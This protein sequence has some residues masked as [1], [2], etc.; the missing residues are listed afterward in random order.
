M[1]NLS[2]QLVVQGLDQ[3]ADRN[4]PDQH[5]VVDHW[6]STTGTEP[7]SWLTNKASASVTA[8]SGQTAIT[9]RPLSSRT[10]RTSIEDLLVVKRFDKLVS[11]SY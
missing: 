8:V 5:S 1:L 3:V 6:Q 4:Q 10:W 9:C 11:T 7:I 2:L